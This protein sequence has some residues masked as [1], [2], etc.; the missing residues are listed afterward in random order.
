M[1]PQLQR[2][3]YSAGHVRRRSDGKGRARRNRIKRKGALAD[4]AS[5]RY[6]RNR[7]HYTAG[8]GQERF[9][10]YGNAV[11]RAE[12]VPVR[13]PQSRPP[14]PKRTS[15]QVR[16]NRNRAMSIS[17]AYAVF[18][19]A[20]AVCAV[21]L[22]MMYL[23]LQS[24]VMNHSKNI[25]AL[26]SELADLTEAMIRHIMQLWIPLICRKLKIKP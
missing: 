2:I 8:A 24:D 20:A 14:Q 23:K 19:A 6:S 21:I 26:Q 22:C 15:R 5:G 13:N 7:R 16:K 9:Y 4:M 25:T 12:A 3:S 11:R 10:V 17:P 18:L 1:L